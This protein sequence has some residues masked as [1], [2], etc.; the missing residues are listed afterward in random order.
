MWLCM[1]WTIIH[2]R[3]LETV[4]ALPIEPGVYR[5]YDD[6]KV[7]L[8]V[9][10]AK[11]LKS[12]VSSYFQGSNDQPKVNAMVQRI[13]SLEVTLTGSELEA[14]LLEFNLIKAH[15]PPY[16]I[17]LKDGKSYPYLLLSTHTYPRLTVHRGPQKSKGKYFGPYPNARSVY[18]VLSGLQKIGKLRNCTDAYFKS[19]KRPCLQHQIKRCSAP[20]VGLVSDSDYQASV[21]QV[22]QVLNGTDEG[23][24][25]RLISQMNAASDNLDYEKASEMRDLIAAIQKL[26]SPQGIVTKKGN[27]DVMVLASDGLQYCVVVLMVR[28][29][30]LLG[31][32]AF[33]PKLRNEMAS[34]SIYYQSIMHHYLSLP[35]TSLFPQH[36]LVTDT[37]DECEALSEVISKHA[38]Q[39][40]SVVTPGRSATR[41]EWV[42]MAKKNAMEAL[43]QQLYSSNSL[44]QRFEHLTHALK[45]DVLIERIDCFDIS[46]F[47]GDSTI[48][49]CV[50]CGLDGPLKSDYRRYGVEGL[51]PG[52][53]YGALFQ[54]LKRHYRHDDTPRPDVLLIDGG[55]GQMLQ[56]EK[57]VQALGLTDLTIMSIAKGAS[58]KPGLE[59]VY[60]SGRDLPLHLQADS[61]ALHLL[62]FVRDEAHRF[63]ITGHRKKRD[64]KALTSILEQIEGVGKTK[65]QALLS[66]FGGLQGVR[67]ASVKALCQ[68][69]GIGTQLAETILAA[70]KEH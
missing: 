61:E 44:F 56:A 37:F 21:K 1:R 24:I 31:H 36:I 69:P 23:L 20:C 55:K 28:Q 63:A 32:N 19:R 62:Q 29:G 66:H 7:L 57:I 2:E 6:N 51:A 4:R 14:L 60:V 9:G 16:N 27:V 3:L 15:R 40:I 22:M 70:L 38:G 50:V 48:G 49:A 67:E 8:Y 34:Q 47:H 12:R 64:K 10:K 5:F 58:R 25:K 54:V 68:V 18:D 46:H 30:K 65:R 35:E 53:D 26:R 13:H 43:K 42:S 45:H 52:D 11:N 41:K 39:S 17:L 59:S 33:F